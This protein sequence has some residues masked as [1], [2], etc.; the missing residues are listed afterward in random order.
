MVLNLYRNPPLPVSRDMQIVLRQAASR[1][2]EHMA[3]H[4]SKRGDLS[5]A[6]RAWRRAQ[7]IEPSFARIKVLSTLIARIMLSEI[8]RL[9]T[10]FGTR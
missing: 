4:L 9:K 1:N 8:S 3:F 2:A 5:G 6:L 7:W 10:L